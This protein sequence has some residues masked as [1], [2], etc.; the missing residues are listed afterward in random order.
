MTTYTSC[1][2]FFNDVSGIETVQT[3][4]YAARV[5]ETMKTLGLAPPVEA[6]LETLAGA[7][8]KLPERGN[9]ADIYLRTLAQSRVTPQR[10]AAHL[11]ICNLIERDERAAE[12][13]S[14]G[15]ASRK[16]DFRRQRHGRVTLGTMRLSLEE[17][18]T[19]R[20]HEFA[21]ALGLA[22]LALPPPGGTADA[23]A[24]ASLAA[25]GA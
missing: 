9:G 25:G 6:F 15:Y 12:C 21:L 3:L 7:R 17:E 14:A 8:S 23:D 10:V 5:V 13:E 16:Q 1:G 19:G 2:W 18:A 4:R 22:P 24:E 20:R 11:A